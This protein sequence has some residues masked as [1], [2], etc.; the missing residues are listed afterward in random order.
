MTEKP[1]APKPANGQ[2]PRGTSGN[3]AGR[4]PGSKNKLPELFQTV[5]DE[6]GPEVIYQ[7]VAAAR[8]G[9]PLAVRQFMARAWP[10]PKERTINLPLP[11]I[12][13]LEDAV[14]ASSVILEAVAN[15]EITHGEAKALLD[16]V[17]THLSLLARA[18]SKKET[19]PIQD[20]SSRGEAKTAGSDCSNPETSKLFSLVGLNEAEQ[21]RVARFDNEYWQV[22][23]RLNEEEARGENENHADLPGPV[24]TS[25]G[26][27][28]TA[29]ETADPVGAEPGVFSSMRLT[30]VL[31]ARVVW[32]NSEYRELDDLVR[33]T[34]ETLRLKENSRTGALPVAG[35]DPECPVPDSQGVP[36]DSDSSNQSGPD[37]ATSAG[38]NDTEAEMAAPETTAK[39]DPYGTAPIAESG[40]EQ[41]VLQHNLGKLPDTDTSH[42]PLPDVVNFGASDGAGA[43]LAESEIAA[44]W[45]PPAPLLPHELGLNGWA[46][47]ITH[48]SEWD[49]TLIRIQNASENRRNRGNPRKGHRVGRRR[50]T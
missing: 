4:P 14:V 17:N 41:N 7:L 47:E 23:E 18:N 11:K 10:I 49:E 24:E 26:E 39:P 46:H 6:N 38:A 48:E 32:L 43:E 35:S 5:I 45:K 30:G 15:G 19:A 33:K 9:H 21:A 36:P 13:N 2:F 28:I 16:L 27:N 1:D 50:A 31:R 12:S 40:S 42:R 44:I 25:G 20:L 8:K 34:E 37:L 29:A 22:D 3:P